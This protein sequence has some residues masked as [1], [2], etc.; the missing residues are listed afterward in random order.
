MRTEKPQAHV[1]APGYPIPV[2]NLPEREP[3]RLTREMVLKAVVSACSAYSAYINDEVLIMHRAHIKGGGM[4][5]PPRTSLVLSRLNA[6]AAD[7]LL[8]KSEFT[9]G[10]YGYRWS[11]TETGRKAL[12]EVS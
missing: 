9:T 6:L 5:S 2:D 1:G 7:G 12:A 8:E 3:F 11:L 10:Y 4:G